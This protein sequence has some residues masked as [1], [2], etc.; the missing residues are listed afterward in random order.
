MTK[1]TVKSRTKRAFYREGICF[2]PEGTPVDQAELGLTDEQ[3]R[4]IVFDPNL[5]VVD[6]EA[7]DA[8]G[9]D[10]QGTKAPA[11]KAAKKAAAK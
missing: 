10:D 7:D 5:V 8:S 3:M 11:K 2:S 9:E 1:I 6:P 4:R